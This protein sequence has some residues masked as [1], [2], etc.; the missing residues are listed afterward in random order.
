MIFGVY[1]L[2]TIGT[3]VEGNRDTWEFLQNL[4]SS[5]E[6]EDSKLLFINI[7]DDIKLFFSAAGVAPYKDCINITYDTGGFM[8]EIPNYCIHDPVKY[9][10]QEIKKKRPPEEI[11]TLIV[12]RGIDE[13]KYSVKNCITVY[14]LKE[15]HAETINKSSNKDAMD[16]TNSSAGNIFKAEDIRL[17]FGGKELNDNQELWFY[18][19]G[20]ESI[21]QMMLRQKV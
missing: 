5:H 13:I 10:I 15:L 17:F 3:R 11:M 19:I 1:F 16:N 2:F 7:L 4:C 6:I 12:R 14:N 21:V 20:Q 18:N 9:E 8:Y